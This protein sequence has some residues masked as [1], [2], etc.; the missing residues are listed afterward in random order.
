MHSSAQLLQAW[1]SQPWLQASKPKMRLA[2]GGYLHDIILPGLCTYFSCLDTPPQE[3]RRMSYLFRRTKKELLR[4]LLKPA[5]SWF[6]TES[7]PPQFSSKLFEN[8]NKE[9]D[10]SEMRCKGDFAVSANH[11][12]R[13]I[14]FSGVQECVFFSFS[15]SQTWGNFKMRGKDFDQ[16]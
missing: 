15:F 14:S 2:L 6:Q 16:H 12:M 5:G 8:K 9:M 1:S 13:H 11:F 3:G 7:S 10:L 4:S